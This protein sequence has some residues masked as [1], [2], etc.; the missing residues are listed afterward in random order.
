MLSSEEPATRG[1][2]ATFERE[3]L[4]HVDRLYRLAMWFVPD[5]PDAPFMPPIP[6]G[7]TD[8]ETLAALARIPSHFQEVILLCDVEELTAGSAMVQRID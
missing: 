5:R 6:Q 8:E 3:A 7:L 2:W 1:R 4:P